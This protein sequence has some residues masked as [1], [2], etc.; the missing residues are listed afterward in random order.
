MRS[1]RMEKSPIVEFEN[2]DIMTV[3]E[4]TEYLRIH[5]TTLYRLLKQKE[6]PAFRIGSDWRFSRTQ[7]DKWRLSRQ[8]WGNSLLVRSAEASLFRTT[9]DG[10]KRIA[11]NILIND[12]LPD[13]CFKLTM[14]AVLPPAF[15]TRFKQILE[16][17]PRAASFESTAGRK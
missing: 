12:A 11:D 4:V 9:E 5:R 3:N 2:D 8:C 1:D 15:L 14:K 6:I 13:I 7:L 16:I 10:R 17:A